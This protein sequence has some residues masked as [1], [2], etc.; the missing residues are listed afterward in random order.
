MSEAS[1]NRLA[2]GAQRDR[3]HQID[4]L[5]ARNPWAAIDLGDAIEV[6]VRRLA[7]HPHLG[8]PGR[9]NGTRELVVSG[10]PLVIAYRIRPGTM[11]ILRVPH[12]AQQ[13]PSR[14]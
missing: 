11:V 13:W 4:Y 5:A 12:G 6:A 10:T 7:D 3:D 1:E 8:R 14:L 2:T 9:V